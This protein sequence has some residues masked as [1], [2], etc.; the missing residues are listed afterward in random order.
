MAG[1]TW[2]AMVIQ[3]AIYRRAL[4]HRHFRR[5]A[6]VTVWQMDAQGGI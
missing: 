6:G 3:K 2:N 1:L 5:I 4:R